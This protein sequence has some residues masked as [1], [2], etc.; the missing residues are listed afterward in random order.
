MYL[1]TEVGAVVDHSDEWESRL[2][3]RLMSH[4][5]NA[6]MGSV[7]NDG[8]SAGRKP[9]LAGDLI[10][11]DETLV[12]ADRGV[13]SG[14]IG[15]SPLNPNVNMG[16]TDVWS[17]AAGSKRTREEAETD[18][19]ELAS[20]VSS[21]MSGDD[22]GSEMMLSAS[23]VLQHRNRKVAAARTLPTVH[24]REDEG[25]PSSLYVER[26]KL[27]RELIEYFNPELVEP[28]AELGGCIEVALG[29]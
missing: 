19:A 13:S 6:E 20:S 24:V 2:F 11:A 4:L 3:R 15:S 29:G 27:Y 5:L 7:S 25:R 16:S 28:R 9:S 1:Q 26:T 14:G 12:A 18:E 8:A 17:G 10:S 22:A 23:Q 21:L